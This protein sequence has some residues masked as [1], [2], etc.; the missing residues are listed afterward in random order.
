MNGRYRDLVAL[1]EF[2]NQAYVI[3]PF[4]NDYD[5]ILLSIS[6]I[7]DPVEFKMFPDQGT[8]IAKAIEEC[9]ALFK[10]FNFLDA[11]GNLLVIFSDGEDTNAVVDGRS[12]DDIAQS[13]IEA[14]VPVYFVRMNFDR[15]RGKN[16]PDDL[17]I[18][19]VEK[20]GGEFFA[21]SD[22]ESLLA[23]IHEIDRVSAGNIQVKEYQQPAAAVCGLRLD[24]RGLP[25]RSHRVEARRTVLSEIPLT[26]RQRAPYSWHG[27]RGVRAAHRV[28]RFSASDTGRSADRR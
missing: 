7:G 21:A 27:H 1:V 18:P 24:H 10:S 11:S 28:S 22:E 25:H 20:T 4:T 9:V 2:G 3:T 12:I 5:N 16:I 17:W 14:K 8:L 6:L 23:A 15:E 19:V 26:T 13:A